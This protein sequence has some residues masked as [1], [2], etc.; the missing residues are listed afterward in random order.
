MGSQW[1]T[2]IFLTFAPMPINADRRDAILDCVDNVVS[3]IRKDTE[4]QFNREEYHK[5]GRSGGH[6]KKFNRIAGR[7]REVNRSQRELAA[8]GCFDNDEEKKLVT[9]EL[10]KRANRFVNQAKS[11]NHK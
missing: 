4:L 5:S 3:R 11:I 8:T 10:A 2:H 1:Q 7:L 6:G 9:T